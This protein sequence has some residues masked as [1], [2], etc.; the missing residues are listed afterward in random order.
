MNRTTHLS[1][2][3]YL[4]LSAVCFGSYGIW[5]KL[6]AGSM[7]DFFQGWTRA[8]MIL[9]ILAIPA[10]KTRAITPF[11]AREMPWV[12]AYSVP[13]ALVI[14]L[15]FYGFTALPIGIATLSF[16][17]CL[18]ITG[19]IL[20]ATVFAERM[21]QRKIAALILGMLGLVLVAGTR[22]AISPSSLLPLLACC[23]A[24]ICGGVEVVL[25]KK[26]S[27]AHSPIQLTMVLYSMTLLQCIL[28]ELIA[29][30]GIV[31]IPTNPIAWMGN[32]AHAVASALAFLLVV[33]GY[34]RTSAA[35]GSIIGLMEIPFGILFG[36]LLFHEPLSVSIM[37]GMFL[38]TFSSLLPIVKK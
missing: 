29:Y 19:Y 28:F 34:K 12:L 36:L 15:F 11:S 17:A 18:T 3:M 25:T 24:G 26:L 13:G 8:L 14:P 37:V 9:A 16:Y 23:I 1:G 21:T 4:L 35:V 22:Y 30:R 7:N 32:I 27:G 38:I 6:M 5:S 20:G 2:P 10:I 31:N 33:S